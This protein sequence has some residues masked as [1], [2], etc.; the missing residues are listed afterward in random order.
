MEDWEQRHKKKSS[1]FKQAGEKCII[2]RWKA[3]LLKE[4]PSVIQ[5]PD[6]LARAQLICMWSLILMRG[7]NKTLKHR[8]TTGGS[9][10]AQLAPSWTILTPGSLKLPPLL[11]QPLQCPEPP[12]LPAHKE[13]QMLQPQPL[14]HSCFGEGQS[15]VLAGAGWSCC[16][17]P[18]SLLS[19]S[20]FSI[21]VHKQSQVLLAAFPFWS[22]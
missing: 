3:F 7:T 13:R 11:R 15:A 16:Q 20:K 6:F 2:N 18:L 1:F 4:K 8:L 9:F 22:N 12:A 10:G 19:L 21:T 17:F 14:P 5:V